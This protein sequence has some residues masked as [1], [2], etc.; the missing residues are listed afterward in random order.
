M[1]TNRFTAIIILF[2]FFIL[3]Y[4]STFLWLYGRYTTAD[5]YYS[6]GFLVPFVTAFFIWRKKEKLRVDQEETARLREEEKKARIKRGKPYDQ[7]EK[8]WLKKK[9][10]EEALKFYGSWPDAQVVTPI[11]RP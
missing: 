2:A 9:P 1:K 10:P 4:H 5:S 7:F 11:F 6:H 8:E 3:I